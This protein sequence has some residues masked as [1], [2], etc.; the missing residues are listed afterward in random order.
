MNII[1]LNI[2]EGCAT[3][4]GGYVDDDGCDKLCAIADRIDHEMVELPKDADGEPIH[5]GDV[6]YGGPGVACKV[7]GLHMSK[8]RWRVDVDELPFF[9]EPGN[10]SHKGP[11]PVDSLE[12]I[13][14]ELEEWSE[15]NRIN[16]NREVFDRAGD[17]ADRIRKLAEKED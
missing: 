9:Y 16:G 5:I 13:A 4:C 8:S 14:D 10:L 1:S 17:L 3:N 2:R 7:V 6:V 15:D 11:E 12:C